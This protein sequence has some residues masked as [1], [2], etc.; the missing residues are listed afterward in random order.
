M[1][2]ILTSLAPSL[3]QTG[4][5]GVYGLSDTLSKSSTYNLLTNAFWT[6][7]LT[8]FNPISWVIIIVGTIIF[9]I[10]ILLLLKRLNPCFLR[11]VKSSDPKYTE[12]DGKDSISG[13]RLFWVSFLPTF[14]VISLI[15]LGVSF[16]I[17][18]KFNQ[19]ST[20]A[21]KNIAGA[22]GGLK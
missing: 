12:C 13:W 11:N 2:E 19:F 21:L 6:T 22:I 1:A 20:G 17:S 16:L 10:I 18:S 5:R 3:I 9:G 14:I 7:Q 8:L 15:V 4:A